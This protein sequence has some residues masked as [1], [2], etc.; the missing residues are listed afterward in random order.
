MKDHTRR[1]HREFLAVFLAIALL[2]GPMSQVARGKEYYELNGEYYVYEEDGEDLEE[3]NGDNLG[4]EGDSGLYIDEDGNLVT[5]P[6]AEQAKEAEQGKEA[7]QAKEAEQGKEAEKAKEDDKV[8]HSA[9][10]GKQSPM[11]SPLKSPVGRP[12]GDAGTLEK[13][14]AGDEGTDGDE[15]EVDDNQPAPVTLQSNYPSKGGSKYSVSFTY[16][17][18]GKSRGADHSPASRL[19]YFYLFQKEQSTTCFCIEPQFFVDRNEHYM[20]TSLADALDRC[21]PGISQQDKERSIR[22]IALALKYYNM[23]RSESQNPDEIEDLTLGMQ[24]Y[25]WSALGYSFNWDKME[26][27]AKSLNKDLEGKINAYINAVTTG[28][29][30]ARQIIELSPGEKIDLEDKKGCLR[31]FSRA[32]RLKPNVERAI[33]SD[34][35]GLYVKWDGK[36]ILTI[37]ADEN[38]LQG[39]TLKFP[40]AQRELKPEGNLGAFFPP[41]EAESK[42]RENNKYWVAAYFSEKSQSFVTIDP[43]VERNEFI[44]S[45]KPKK[46]G[47]DTYRKFGQ[48]ALTVSAEDLVGFKKMTVGQAKP[49]NEE[50]E[51]NQN[52]EENTEEGASPA[53]NPSP[54]IGRSGLV[55]YQPVYAQVLQSKRLFGIHAGEDL[56]IL[57]NRY[58]KGTLMRLLFSSGRDISM[59]GSL[60]F[61]KYYLQEYTSDRMEEVADDN[62]E[63]IRQLQAV[64]EPIPFEINRIEDLPTVDDDNQLNIVTERHMVVN[65]QDKVD[66]TPQ[67]LKVTQ[68]LP[69]E[70]EDPF[71][72][73][74]NTQVHQLPTT[75]ISISAN[76]KTRNIPYVSKLEEPSWQSHELLEHRAKTQIVALTAREDLLTG[77]VLPEETD[78]VSRIS[79]DS[80]IAL[81]QEKTKISLGIEEGSQDPDQTGEEE[82]PE[83]I[84]DY[85]KQEEKK[86][87]EN[88]AKSLTGYGYYQGV[89]A[90]KGGELPLTLKVVNADPAYNMAQ[91][92]AV[93]WASLRQNGGSWKAWP[94]LQE[95]LKRFPVQ[96]VKVDSEEDRGLEGAEFLLY[97]YQPGRGTKPLPGKATATLVTDKTGKAWAK[98]LE[99]GRYL[100]QETKA[101]EGYKILASPVSFMIG[102]ETNKRLVI[103]NKKGEDGKVAEG[104]DAVEP[105][106]QE[107]PPKKEEP[108]NPPK[109]NKP[110][111]EEENQEPK[112]TKDTKPT[113]DT[114]ET[115]PSKATGDAQNTKSTAPTEGQPQEKSESAL[116]DLFAPLKLFTKKG[117]EDKKETEDIKEPKDTKETK[118]TTDTKETKATT[119]PS[120]TKETEE[121]KES[122]ANS[123]KAQPKKLKRLKRLSLPPDELLVPKAA[124]KSSPEAVQAYMRPSPNNA[125]PVVASRAFHGIPETGERSLA[126]WIWTLISIAG[127]LTLCRRL[128]TK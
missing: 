100:L 104:G 67:P 49:R 71:A 68:A 103:Q 33:G 9:L 2:L 62:V 126:P 75:Y 28:P 52:S 45:V 66:R 41:D 110:Q 98:G 37:R 55:L 12:L 106:P 105:K 89:F 96:V 20:P 15:E 19:Q 86:Q 46:A 14:P 48:L 85:D 10:G 38:F 88:E 40:Y 1:K 77:V 7:Q 27:E 35:G 111:D 43:E 8:D 42:Y 59:S 54:A 51:N 113:G 79:A 47:R 29:S 56:R 87:N 57:N 107:D 34:N 116:K 82:E 112:K 115:D 117:K 114:E 25:I 61:G 16:R 127:I 6:E 39:Q 90:W 44:L 36:N 128:K 76:A 120:G 21:Y 69:Q 80:L 11:G 50:N 99:Y 95:T 97:G 83:D 13:K 94:S 18:S 124:S 101:P 91:A 22:N 60:T 24:A 53:E 70:S 74:I 93:N 122:Q 5:Q 78:L 63:A 72:R 31:Y 32:S 17:G 123:T 121:T 65:G 30:F 4:A 119:E 23:A 73:R 92:V 84:V 102:Q 108:E 3:G 125:Q 109:P 118:D 81:Q 64:G 58:K 26:D